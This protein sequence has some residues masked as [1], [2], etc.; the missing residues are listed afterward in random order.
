M[1]IILKLEK[2]Q[3]KIIEIVDNGIGINDLDLPKV[4]IPFYSTKPGGTGIGLTLSRHIMQQHNA[5]IQIV[6]TGISGCSVL[7][8]FN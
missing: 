8:K 7:L 1:T 6:T 3:Y 4:F 5:T 2:N